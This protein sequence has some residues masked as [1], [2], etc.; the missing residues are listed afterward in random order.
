MVFADYTVVNLR[1]SVVLWPFDSLVPKPTVVQT[2]LMGWID[3]WGGGALSE[4]PRI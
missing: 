1:Q 3:P 2:M 4:N